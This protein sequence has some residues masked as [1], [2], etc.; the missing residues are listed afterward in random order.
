M[1]P[2]L[3]LKATVVMGLALAAARLMGRAPA[4]TRHRLWTI[5]FA[6]LLALPLLAAALPALPVPVPEWALPEGGTKVPPLHLM[7]RDGGAEVSPLHVIAQVPSPQA[8]AGD[9]GA[10]AAPLQVIAQGPPPQAITTDVPSP[11]AR[12]TA[13]QVLLGAWVIGT[14]AAALALMLSLLRARRLARAAE[15]ITDPSWR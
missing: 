4:I 15:E 1:D 7:E 3:L 5:A 12:V 2:M 13:T 11:R 8:M 9:G 10:E 14:C 6:A